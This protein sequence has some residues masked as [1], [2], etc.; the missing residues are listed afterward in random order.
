MSE[1]VAVRCVELDL[2]FESIVAAAKAFGSGNAGNISS[3]I[4]CNTKTAYGYHWVAVKPGKAKKQKRKKPSLCWE[5]HRSVHFKECP[6][7]WAARFEPVPGWKAKVS[8]IK[9]PYGTDKTYHVTKCPL[10]M[11]E[12]RRTEND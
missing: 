4:N 12:G 2:E 7:P 5:C 8:H 1:K 6:C 11:A 10:F 9:T 3:C